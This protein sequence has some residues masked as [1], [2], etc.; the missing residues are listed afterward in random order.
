MAEAPTTT[1]AF[2]QRH[3]ILGVLVHDVTEDEAVVWVERFVQEGRPHQVVT[4]NPEFVMRARRDPVFRETLNGADLAVPDGVGLIWAGRLLGTRFRGRVPGVELTRRLAGLAAARGYR[5]YLLGAGPGVAEE[6]ARRLQRDN[7]DL[8]IAGTYA[9]SPDPAEEE[10]IL[11]RIRRAAPQVLLVAYGAPEQD[12]W[13]RRNLPRLGGAVGVGVGGSFDYISGRVSRAP[14]W[15]RRIGLEWL[16]RLLHQPWRW[17]RMLALPAF[18]L[19]VLVQALTRRLGRRQDRV[20]AE[21]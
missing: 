8:V 5:F 15:M 4:V 7:P 1:Q 12:F 19:L 20:P 11:A 2:P 13:L 3:S 9:G 14:A 17:R 10:K 16:Y 21:R 18:G 6:A